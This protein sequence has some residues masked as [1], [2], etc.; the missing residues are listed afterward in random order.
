MATPSAEPQVVSNAVVFARQSPQ[1]AALK[2][3]PATP[4]R[5]TL[6]RLNGRLIWDE[7][8]TVR[9][10]APWAGRVVRIQADS[11]T[12]VEAG[13]ELALLASPDYGQAQADALRAT[14]DLAQSVKTLARLKDLEAHG[15]AARKDLEAAEA[16]HDRAE[17]ELQRASARLALYGGKAQAVDQM[18]ALRSPVAGYVVERNLNP[19]QEVRTDQMLANVDR[20]AAP[21]FVISDPERLWVQID[22]TEYDLPHLKTGQ[23][24]RIRSQVY[25]DEVFEGKLEVVQDALDPVSHMVRVRGSVPNASRRLKSE[26]Y[27]TV[28]IQTEAPAGVDVAASAVFLRD[29]R[30]YVYMEVE[31]GR[32]LRREVQVGPERN[33]RILIL[34]PLGEGVR[35]VQEGALLLE[36][37]YQNGKSS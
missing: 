23:V 19:G 36:G 24:I 7:L 35:V 34:N 8:A 10:F 2:A 11:G 4:S 14:S 29:E 12:R 37:I 22:A 33:G 28:E 21:L 26:M 27:V 5:G 25:P 16:D 18:V 9:V 15:A 17:A 6:L 20:V 13:D 32:Y 31:P 30:H 3:E 1:L